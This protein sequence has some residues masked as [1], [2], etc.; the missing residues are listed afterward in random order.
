MIWV[1]DK[2]V[3]CL[4]VVADEE[5]VSFMSP[6]FPCAGAYSVP[7]DVLDRIYFVGYVALSILY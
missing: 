2:S 7:E 6:P 5:N 4:A 3:E 1:A